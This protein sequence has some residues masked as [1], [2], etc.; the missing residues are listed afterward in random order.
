VSQEIFQVLL[1]KAVTNQINLEKYK[2]SLVDSNI[3]SLNGLADRIA[4]L[5]SLTDFT[6]PREVKDLIAKIYLDVDKTLD[7]LREQIQKEI[8]LFA[9]EEV[10]EEK[11]VIGL[12]LGESEGTPVLSG[13][14]LIMGLSLSEHFRK[15]KNDIKNRSR[16][17]ILNAAKDNESPAV[18]SRRIRGTKRRRFMDGTFHSYRN[19]FDAIVRTAIQTYSTQ[20]KMAVWKHR[21]IERYVWISVLDGKTTPICR[22]RSNKVYTV[23]EGPTPPAHHRC[24]SLISPYNSQMILPQSYSSW[25]RE[26]PK[27]T[28]E[29]V[30]GKGKAKIFL[31]GNITLD[32]F[33]VNNKPLTLE[34]LKQ[35]RNRPSGTN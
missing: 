34:E 5:I 24:R 9:K 14:L 19:S 17:E 15:L 33:V 27:E 1:N 35:K 26:Q 12:L 20:A 23:G 4:V 29:D 11:H 30:L 25:L 28:I 21:D 6:N 16:S 18:V 32:K 13:S 22:A 8:A 10:D 7:S 31:E 2:R 3:P